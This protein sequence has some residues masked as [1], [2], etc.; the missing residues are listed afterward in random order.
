MCESTTTTTYIYMYLPVALVV[1]VIHTIL[2]YIICDSMSKII[3][4]VDIINGSIDRASYPI[5]IYCTYYVVANPVHLLLDRTMSEE[6]LQTLS[7]NESMK[8]KTKQKP[9]N[10]NPMRMPE[11]DSTVKRYKAQH[12]TSFVMEQPATQTF[13]F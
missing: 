3:C 5:I 12:V 2:S 11:I 9:G 10:N 6:H 8:E 13:L 1:F 4:I 7:Y